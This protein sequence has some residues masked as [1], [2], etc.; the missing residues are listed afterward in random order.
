[1]RSKLLQQ[2]KSITAIPVQEATV[3]TAV[4]GSAIA[5]V[6]DNGALGL[7]RSAII[8]FDAGI[9]STGTTTYTLSVQESDTTTDGD[10]TDVT[11]TGTL[12]TVTPTASVVDSDYFYLKTAGLKKYFRIVATP[13]GTGGATG[14]I[15]AVAVLGDGSVESLPRG[16]VPTVYAKA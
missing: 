12:P 8:H 15:A 9:T 16:T 6:D 11:L 7:T 4:K 1:M 2:V 3:G 13:T 14:N 10:F 5:H